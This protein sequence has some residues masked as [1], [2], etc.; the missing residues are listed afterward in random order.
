MEEDESEKNMGKVDDSEAEWSDCN[1]DDEGDGDGGNKGEPQKNK[2][3]ASEAAVE[4][5]EEDENNLKIDLDATC[6]PSTSSAAFASSVK[7]LPT[8]KLRVIKSRLKRKGKLTRANKAR[9]RA[10][11]STPGSEPAKRRRKKRQRLLSTEAVPKSVVEGAA[12]DNP[13]LDK[14]INASA[15]K[16]GLNRT[17]VKVVLKQM[18]QSPDLLSVFM[19]EAGDPTVEGASSTEKFKID[20]VTDRV[21]RMKASKVKEDGGR[22]D[23]VLEKIEAMNNLKTPVKKGNS[24]SGDKI[25]KDLPVAE[26]PELPEEDPDD[27]EYDPK[28]DPEANAAG[29]DDEESLMTNSEVGTPRTQT[30][31]LFSSP[32]S[33][34]LETPRMAADPVPGAPKAASSAARNLSFDCPPPPA[35]PPPPPPQGGLV[36]GSCDPNLGRYHSKEQQQ[37]QTRSRSNLKDVPIEQLE[38]QFVPPDITPDMYNMEVDDYG[39]FL[40]D[41]YSKP[42][43]EDEPQRAEDN[44][45]APREDAEEA[46][47]EWIWDQDM[48]QETHD[49]VQWDRST[50]VS[51]VELD[52]LVSDAIKAY[53]LD[54]GDEGKG[55]S[56]T[57]DRSRPGSRAKKKDPKE[58][59]DEYYQEMAADQAPPQLTQEQ[60][61]TLSHQIRQHI[62]LLTSMTMLTSGYSNASEEDPELRHAHK[63]NE[64]CKTMMSELYS[65]VLA[66][67]HSNPQPMLSQPTLHGSFR[68][69]DEWERSGRHATDPETVPKNL[70]P[71]AALRPSKA[72]LSQLTDDFKDFV[73]GCVGV[74]P[75]P[76]L[77]PTVGLNLSLDPMGGAGWTSGEDRLLLL[78]FDT[79]ESA[80]SKKS[81]KRDYISTHIAAINRD[82]I[83][84]KT[85]LQI[86]KHVSNVRTRAKKNTENHPINLFFDHGILEK[87][88]LT[89]ASWHQLGPAQATREAPPDSLPEVY[90]KHWNP[91]LLESKRA[92]TSAAKGKSAPV[93]FSQR[94]ANAEP[95]FPAAAVFEYSH[96]G[97]GAVAMT[98]PEGEHVVVSTIEL[99]E[100]TVAKAAAAAA[101][102]L[103]SSSVK[104]KNNKSIL[105]PSKATSDRIVKKYKNQRKKGSRTAVSSEMSDPKTPSPTPP[106]A[107]LDSS[108]SPPG[109]AVQLT[110]LEA[111][112]EESGIEGGKEETAAVGP[113]VVSPGPKTAVVSVV[114]A[115]AV[116]A[117]VNDAV[118][119]AN[120]DLLAAFERVTEVTATAA[121]QSKQQ[122]PAAA[123]TKM[124]SRQQRKSSKV[125][126][127][128][129][130]T[131]YMLEPETASELAARAQRE[132]ED[133][134]KAAERALG[135][136][137]QGQ[138]DE[139]SA[140][141]KFL[142]AAVEFE[143]EPVKA[144]AAMHSV[145]S[146]RV[147]LQE[148]LLDLLR[149]EHA[150]SLGAPVYDQF[151]MR[152]AHKEFF[153]KLRRYYEFQ[154]SFKRIKLSSLNI[155]YAK[156]H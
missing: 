82:Y 97:G 61:W 7:K 38:N 87:E 88:D 43:Q 50:K 109:L 105:S 54:A 28:K 20:M 102:A 17:Q 83:K 16:L 106:P 23:W 4:E 132:A 124:S 126:R 46:D 1:S 136:T 29:S 152:Q 130:Q 40:Q 34:M 57:K 36:G 98:I 58:L 39:L 13:D 45:E 79:L 90:L 112:I 94:E 95:G 47:P 131:A 53:D 148:M 10:T 121:S 78:A 139:D 120:M 100:E 31:N 138:P 76:Q 62:Q 65:D 49:E 80:A 92:A 93:P 125:Q 12:A 60:H 122:L 41:T 117:T 145:C 30:S 99:T 72:N 119:G 74:F 150:V 84:A 133:V 33:D 42:I 103:S 8:P 111:A 101:N 135:G 81:T 24:G 86:R 137:G 127:G 113:F 151:R 15:A 25:D 154:G 107:D 55:N 27:D 118:Q 143:R 149:P 35:P 2:E 70:K 26:L 69:T 63:V 115:E 18:L 67:Q 77:L 114:E 134:F 52:D 128:A 19:K 21:T 6:T 104:K 51:R 56:Q 155:Y 153:R 59:L 66:K 96:D 14:N 147:W 75:Y 156:V 44:P 123:A 85:A 32:Q 89:Y 91:G 73:G 116:T 64:N 142:Q 71:K 129:E 140:L 68:T 144:F 9:S 3:K 110:I 141:V 48:L 108:S 22:L 5:E 11:L 146:G 37:R